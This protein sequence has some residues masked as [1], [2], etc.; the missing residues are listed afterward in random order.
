MRYFF[1]LMLPLFCFACGAEAPPAT[2]VDPQLT[3]A[4]GTERAPVYQRFSNENF[5]TMRDAYP[6]APLIDVRT[7]EEYAAGHI[8]GAKNINLYDADF[9][10]RI[11]N[12]NKTYPILVYCQ[13]GGRS[14]QAC[15]ALQEMGFETIYELKD[16]YGKW[17]PGRGDLSRKLYDSQ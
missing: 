11:G 15:E 8:D 16:G 1:L 2:A 4:P 17:E 3:A 9:R 6:S 5:N 14:N 7:P 10:E 12:Y 13:K